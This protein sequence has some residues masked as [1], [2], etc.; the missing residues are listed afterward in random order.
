HPEGGDFG[1]AGAFAAAA[2]AAVPRWRPRRR[3]GWPQELGAW[4]AALPR[5]CG[6]WAANDAAGLHLIEAC[7]A[8]GLAIPG[9]L[10]VLGCDDD[11]FLC[12]LSDPTLSSVAAPAY[13]AGRAAAAMLAALLAGRRPAA[14][15]LP[16][17]RLVV[18]ASSDGSAAEDALVAQA[19]A[20]L[21]GEHEVG[22]VA[23][24]ARRLGVSARSLER[25]CRKAVGETPGAL[26]RR[27][28]LEQAQHLLAGSGLGVAAIAARCGYANASR[29]G[30]AMRRATGLSP[31]AWRRSCG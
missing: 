5:P 1:R 29:L 10:A 18:R 15:E 23:G 19:L 16:P 4:L 7:R 6:I 20:R 9:E 3:Q 21:S 26:L 28:R 11:E 24:L 25:R 31:R 30:E 22:T 12:R 27:R 2:G 17:P 14:P 13:A 8:Q